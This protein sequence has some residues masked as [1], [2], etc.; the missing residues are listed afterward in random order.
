MEIVYSLLLEQLCTCAIHEVANHKG[1]SLALVGKSIYCARDY[2]S[3]I[4]IFL[5]DGT[6]IYSRRNYRTAKWERHKR[7]GGTELEYSQYLDGA[8]PTRTLVTLT[9]SKGVVSTF[10][11]PSTE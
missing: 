1:F 3:S 7:R 9:E 2:S 10:R 8:Q 4:R 6:Y 11:Q 5:H